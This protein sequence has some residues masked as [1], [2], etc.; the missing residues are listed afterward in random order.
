M[1]RFAKYHGLGNDFIVLDRLHGGDRM[2]AA[3]AAALC[4]RHRGVGAD[5]VL[6]LWPDHDASARMEVH[7]A[8]GSESNMCGNGLRCAARY[9]HD[10]GM[11]TAPLVTLKLGG[12]VY[13]CERSAP[14]R[15]R[16]AMGAPQERHPDLPGPAAT[17]AHG[18]ARFAAHCVH[19]GNPH[20]VIFTDQDPMSL[21]RAHGAALAQHEGFPRGANVSFARSTAEGFAAVVYERGV[22]ITEACGS[23]ATAIGFAAVGEGRWPAQGPLRVELPGG[24]LTITVHVTGKVD[25]EGDTAHVFDGEWRA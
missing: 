10:R 5:G 18:D 21:A 2:T 22:G 12:V 1:L 3:L 19:V 23:G 24:A 14:G 25:M 8:D 17:L 9:L 20:A 15:Y 7:N 4:D 13:P 11:V 6:S 16:V